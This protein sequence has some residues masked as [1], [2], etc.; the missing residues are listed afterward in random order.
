M[1]AHH[2]LA[3]HLLSTVDYSSVYIREFAIIDILWGGGRG[4]DT[5]YV[6]KND[7]VSVS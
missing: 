4:G 1:N 5:R 3:N 7:A 2:E 6:G